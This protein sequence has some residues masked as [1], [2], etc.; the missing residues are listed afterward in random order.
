MEHIKKQ[1]TDLL[2]SHATKAH[3][4]GSCGELGDSFMAIDSDSFSDLANE[5]LQNFEPKKCMPEGINS[6]EEHEEY[7]KAIGY[8][9][10]VKDLE[11]HKD[12]TVG[13]YATDKEPEKLFEEVFVNLIEEIGMDGE[14]TFSPMDYEY[15]RDMF[16]K[17]IKMLMFRIS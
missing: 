11:H 1:I 9:K 3:G 16:N 15:Y 17:G 14:K 8:E 5:I 10:H 13:L 6:K 4:A 7:L 12:T 2:W